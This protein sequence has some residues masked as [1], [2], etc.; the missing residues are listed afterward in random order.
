MKKTFLFA[1]FFIFGCAST[2]QNFPKPNPSVLD[3]G[4]AR[5]KLNRIEEYVGTALTFTIYD[6]GNLVGKL[7]RDK[8]LEWD[9]PAGELTLSRDWSPVNGVVDN[10][11]VTFMTEEGYKYELYAGWYD[12]FTSSSSS[13]RSKEAMSRIFT[14]MLITGIA[15]LN[16]SP[17]P[18]LSLG[19]GGDKGC[20]V[21][22]K[23]KFVSFGED[24][25][26]KFVD[27]GENL[28]IK[29]VDFG[30]NQVGRWKVVEFG[31]NYKIKV[32]DF[33]EDFSVKMVDFGEG[34]N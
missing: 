1:L 28:K 10:N 23:I 30:E 18:S 33:G 8:P 27:F 24:Y 20:H 31:E 2:T 25:K 14:G 34:C 29:Y 17:T 9:R 22:G 12:G 3:K 26:V 5:I 15:N 11:S 21:Y 13:N 16:T 19:T 7:G 32:V 6:N 4:K